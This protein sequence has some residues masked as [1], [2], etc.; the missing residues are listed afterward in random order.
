MSASERRAGYMSRCIKALKERDKKIN[1]Y[2]ELKMCEKNCL[3]CLFFV[4]NSASENVAKEIER[5]SSPVKEDSRKGLRQNKKVLKELVSPSEND[6]VGYSLA[7]HKGCW[8][9]GYRSS[10]DD[11]WQEITKNR[12]AKNSR[13]NSCFYFEFQDGMLLAA[14][15]E[16][17]KRETLQK[18]TAADRRWIKWGVWAT[19]FTAFASIVVFV[20]S[21]YWKS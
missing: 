1:N 20:W 17:E 19:F 3:N 2:G 16:L 4:R 8:D 7:C 21:H 14:A 5:H 18:E 11:I 6:S 10:C 15:D 13:C 9:G 12:N